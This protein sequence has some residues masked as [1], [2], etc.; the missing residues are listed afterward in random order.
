MG[1]PM[2]TSDNWQALLLTLQLSGVTTLIL[3]L[4]CTPL[5]WWLARSQFRYKFLLDALAALPLVLPPTVIGFY[6]LLLLGSN[7]P[8]ARH[9]DINLAF[10]FWGLVVGSLIYSLPFVLQPLQDSFRSLG[11]QPL[12]TA[13]TLRM[14]PWDRFFRL[15]LP[16]CRNGF[17]T[18]TVLGFAHTLGEFGVVLMIG[19]NIP[20]ETRVASIA[21]YEHVESLEYGQAHALSLWVIAIAATLL[22]LAYGFT[23]RRST[24]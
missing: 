20:G 7:G 19:G 9:L 16:L 21:I 14:G 8:L 22:I 2:L 3:L 23:R 15:V 13:S 17:L 18:A 24:L 4:V 5:A 10:S 1:S 11:E 12:E 6:L